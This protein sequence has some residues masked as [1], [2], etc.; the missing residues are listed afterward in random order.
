MVT[1]KDIANKLGISVSTV[2]KGLNNASDISDE[3]RQLVLDT[4]IEM[5]YTSKKMKAQVLRK[6]C[7][8]IENMG[9]EIIDQFGYEIIV[10]FKLSA[11]RR[12][13]DV[14]V[15]PTNL[16]MQTEEK[17]DTYMLKNGYCGAFLLGFTLHDDWVK[18]LNKTTVPTVLLDNY[19]ENNPHVGY[20]GTDSYEGIDLA[21]HHLCNLGHKKIAFLNGSKNSMVSEQRRQ[22][23]V[24]SMLKYG[25]EPDENL[26][27]YGYYVPDCAKDHVPSFL[28]QGATAIMCAS[29]LIATGVMAEITRHGLKIPDDI[30]VIGFDDLPIASQL[31]PS[32]TTIRQDRTDL[33]KSAFLLL[34]G[35]VHGIA[36]SKLLLRAK[37]IE[38]ESTGPVKK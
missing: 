13:W 16:N 4:A 15:V 6:V 19:I 31:S 7:I 35:L 24:N 3:M 32:L 18:Q 33:G 25:L 1:I 30:S 36:T 10:G 27:R 14:T 34:D 5:G 22:A 9:Y 12:K 2:S 28:K 26:I 37:F 8:L 23:F 29:D 11:A 21:V 20:V 17:Y 38:R